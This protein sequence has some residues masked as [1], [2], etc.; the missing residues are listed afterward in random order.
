MR[1]VAKQL[2]VGLATVSKYKNEHLPELKMS[3]GGGISK[4]TDAKKRIIKR[5]IMT[6]KLKTAAEVFRDLVNEGYNVSYTTVRRTL[7]S[8]GFMAK[9]K[10]RNPSYQKKIFKIVLNGLKS[11]NIGQLKTGKEL[12]GQMKQK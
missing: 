6:G 5:D 12:Y 2:G 4:I 8:M 3:V 11:I 10:K 9:I 7:N 1:N